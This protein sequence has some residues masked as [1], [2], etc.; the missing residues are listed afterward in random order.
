MSKDEKLVTK[1]LVAIAIVIIGFLI[2]TFFGAFCSVPKYALGT[3]VGLSGGTAVIISVRLSGR[4]PR[5]DLVLKNGKVLKEV[6]ESYL[7]PL[8]EVPESYL[9]PL[10]GYHGPC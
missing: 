6:P 4:Y 8:K 2:L 5:Y 10:K 9:D 1:V 7:D 3:T